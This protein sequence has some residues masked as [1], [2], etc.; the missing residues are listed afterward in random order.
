MRKMTS[1]RVGRVE[2]NKFRLQLQ[3]LI[4]IVTYYGPLVATA[5]VIIAKVNNVVAWWTAVA[6]E[7]EMRS[8]QS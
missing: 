1:V 6:K 5:F 3:N 2:M 8:T 7:L 4:G